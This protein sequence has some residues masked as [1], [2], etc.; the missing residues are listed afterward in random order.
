[1]DDVFKQRPD[2][3]RGRAGRTLDGVSPLRDKSKDDQ[4]WEA[5]LYE[6]AGYGVHAYAV[7]ARKKR[8]ARTNGWTATADAQQGAG[9]IGNAA[10]TNFEHVDLQGRADVRQ[11]SGEV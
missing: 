11:E 5:Q 4:D 6:G 2:D 10:A 3:V 9:D 8:L 7:A 1:M